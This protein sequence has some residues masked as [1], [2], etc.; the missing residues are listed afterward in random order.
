MTS[1]TMIGAPTIQCAICQKTQPAHGALEFED[2]EKKYWACNDCATGAV[3]NLHAWI[4][5]LGPRKIVTFNVHND[6][7]AGAVVTLAY[8]KDAHEPR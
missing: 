8:P 4:A 6:L 1:A 2:F 7:E 3:S 5:R